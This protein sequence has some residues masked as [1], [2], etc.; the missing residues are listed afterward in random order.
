M[1]K[2]Y[3]PN[4]VVTKTGL[5]PDRV[6]QYART[7]NLQKFAGSYIW[8]EADIEELERTKGHPGRKKKNPEE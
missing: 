6:R 8:R 7:H 2:L 5:S 3:T 4:D 1:E